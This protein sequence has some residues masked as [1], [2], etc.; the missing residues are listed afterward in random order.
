MT[1]NVFQYDSLCNLH[2]F[3]VYVQGELDG[4]G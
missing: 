4:Q 3:T 2:G 1:N